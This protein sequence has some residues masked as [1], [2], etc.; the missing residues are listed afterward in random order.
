MSFD[1]VVLGGNVDGMVAAAVLAKEGRSVLLTHLSPELGDSDRL[2]LDASCL[3]PDVAS[4]IGLTEDGLAWADV[5]PTYVVHLD[6]VLPSQMGGTEYEVDRLAPADAAAWRAAS[7]YVMT[8]R[9]LVRDQ[10][11]QVPPAI[12]GLSEPF[13]LL[14]RAASSLRVGRRALLELARTAPQS[15][16]DTLDDLGMSKSLRGYLGARGLFGAWMGPWSPEST[17]VWLAHESLMHRGVQGGPCALIDA[18]VASHE[19]LGVTRRATTV[20]RIDVAEGAVQAVILEDG[21][22]VETTLVISAAHPRT[23]LLDWVDPVQLPLALEDEVRN[24]RSR[25]I[26]ARMELTFEGG[27]SWPGREG[28]T[29]SRAWL[30]G[31]S[32]CVERAFDPCKY[33]EIAERPVLDLRVRAGDGETTLSI[34][35]TGIPYRPDADDDGLVVDRVMAV[36]EETVPGVRTRLKAQQ[37]WT[38]ATIAEQLGAPGGHLRHGELGIDQLW[39]GRPSPSTAR[40]RTAIKGLYLG[41]PGSHPGVGLTGEAGA[42]AALS[43]LQ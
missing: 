14:R 27:W 13:A 4:T 37:V 22:R 29:L 28:Q 30:G 9:R 5:E 8:Y 19:R 20:Q 39:V 1:A 18:L 40:Y 7:D 10:M 25:G 6:A 24:V 35:A 21:T 16:E 34:L 31:D 3:D 15:I 38:P 33:G 17:A 42:L 41:G 23:T 11:L 12:L 26:V 36:L 2:L 32:R 43:S